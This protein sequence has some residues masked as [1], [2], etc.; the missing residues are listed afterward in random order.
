[1]VQLPQ[2]SNSRGQHLQLIRVEVQLLNEGIVEQRGSQS[3]QSLAAKVKRIPT[4]SAS[5]LSCRCTIAPIRP[6]L[7]VSVV[8]DELDSFRPRSVLRSANAWM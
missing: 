2:L 7:C 1:M 3:A 4:L 8:G 6:I 5:W